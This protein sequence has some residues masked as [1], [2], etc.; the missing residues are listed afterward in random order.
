MDSHQKQSANREVRMILQHIGISL[1]WILF[2]L[3]RIFSLAPERSA[4]PTIVGCAVALAFNAL[5]IHFLSR[6]KGR[7]SP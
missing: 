5:L 2:A 3:I 7:E 1:F 6:S 4:I